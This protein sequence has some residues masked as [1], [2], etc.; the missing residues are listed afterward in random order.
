MPFRYNLQKI[1]N[2]RITK[3]DE[4]LEVVR[5]AQLEVQRIQQEID[6]K[7]KEIASVQADMRHAQ[8]IMLETYDNF[9]KHLYKQ[10]AELEIQKE[11][12]IRIL[13]E[14]KKKLEEYEQ[15]VKVLE[16]HKEKK[17]EE[18]LKEEKELELKQ[19]NETAS[20]K[21]FRMQRE[22]QEELELEEYLQQ[23]GNDDEY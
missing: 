5:K 20:I 16:K 3:R 23:L 12:A 13:E 11:E 10:I 15:N 1:L 17:K 14:E 4:Q 2:F 7:Y 18:Y 6:N 8:P 21:H 22:Q 9:I 19:L